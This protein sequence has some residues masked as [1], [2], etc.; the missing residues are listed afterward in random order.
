MPG[1][2]LNTVPGAVPDHPGHA[3]EAAPG[4]PSAW[5]KALSLP[6]VL[7]GMLVC[8][9]FCFCCLRFSDPDAWW[10]LKMGQEIWQSH[11]IPSSD[12]WSF[13]VP[14]HSW[15]AHE[16]LAE[17][18]L[19]LAFS[20]AGYQGL[21]LWLCLLASAFVAA[22]YVL[23]YRHCGSPSAALLGGFLAFFFGTMGFALR[24]Q[25]IG[26]LLLVFELLILQSAW[27]SPLK[28]RSRLLWWLPPMFVV[29]VNSHG[30][31]AL[32][33]GI[34]ALA[35]AFGYIDDRRTM[36]LAIGL[37]G[38]CALAL[39][40]NPV[41]I[42][43]LTY[44]FNVFVKQRA[45]LG[46]L[47]EWLPSTMQDVRGFVLFLVLGG[48]G[49]AGL[50]GRARL[51]AFELLLFVPITFL[52]LQHVR[53]V[54]VFGIVAAPIVSRVVANLRAPAVRKPDHWPSHAFLLAIVALCCYAT[55]PRVEKIQANIESL[56]PV[57]A[58]AF[59]RSAGLQGPMLNDYMWGG[60]LVWALP[61][62]KV[63]IDGRGDVYDWAGVLA[64]YRDWWLIQA[65]PTGLLDEYRIQFCLLPTS[66]QMANVMPRLHGWKKLYGDDVA[67]VF[68]RE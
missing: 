4:Q 55:F 44:P 17:V 56:N 13:T 50:T 68:G 15:I 5:R 38:A 16:W 54:F 59:I 47:A 12:H 30:S 10:H 41:G 58:V 14:G 66:A 3:A 67:V 31:Y 43:L 19:F 65:D 20:V 11:A 33:G 21:Q 2:T 60:Y 39:L 7:C 22:M 28:F 25:M 42:K 18:S 61:E 6:V 40:V 62:H 34:L 51:T 63:F 9:T 37:L 29:W 26:Y 53:M 46:F 48:I 8:L 27:Q 36:K 23:C 49:V 52:A 32:G 24:P 57:K 45:S 64:R 35:L 1:L